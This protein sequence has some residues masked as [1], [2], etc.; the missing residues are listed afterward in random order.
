MNTPYVSGMFVE[1][2]LGVGTH[3][4]SMAAETEQ[5]RIGM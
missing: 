2:F 1:L 5:N 4:A 3:A